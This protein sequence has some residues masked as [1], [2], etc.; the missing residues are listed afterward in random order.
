MEENNNLEESFKLG[1]SVVIIGGKEIDIF[2]SCVDGNH[3]A[4]IED[5]F[6]KESTNYRNGY[7]YRIRCSCGSSWVCNTKHIIPCCDDIKEAIRIKKENEEKLRLLKQEQ[8]KEKVKIIE[9]AL[10][11]VY[12]N[13]W[14]INVSD[15]INIIILYPEFEIR[16]SKGHTHI[17]KD[18]YIKLTFD[19]DLKLISIKGVRG[20]LTYEEYKS[21]YSHSHLSGS[22][23]SEFSSF[24]LGE[25]P[26][27]ITKVELG[28]E[29]NIDKFYLFLHLLNSYVRWESLEGG[30]YSK[31]A[32]INGRASSNS[33]ISQDILVKN[34]A[35]FLT[36]YKDFPIEFNKKDSLNCFS[37]DIKNTV[38]LKMVDEVA[39]NK[40][41]FDESTR[42]YLTEQIVITEEQLK[43]INRNPYYFPFTFKGN[44]INLNII[45]SYSSND[46]LK[47]VA[48]PDIVNYI[49]K[50]LSVKINEFYLTY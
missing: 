21:N 41:K 39:T 48:H 12:E 11:D 18:L 46:N 29:F 3:V 8:N 42:E 28:R 33:T 34:Y 44:T 16:N 24:C 43:E 23:I 37:I 2:D 4:N 40:V 5:I 13:N 35:L 30:P 50:E 32:Y 26:V 9:E 15:K 27:A 1:D 6:S 17:I 49:A 31:I 10:R 20:V 7:H 47:E 36:K 22:G 45:K 25:S 14:D 38:F 19:I